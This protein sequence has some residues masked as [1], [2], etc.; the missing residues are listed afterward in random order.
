MLIGTAIGGRFLY[1]YFIGAGAGHMQS[2]ILASMMIV[3]GVQ[4]AIVGLQGDIIA[5]NRKLLEDIQYRVKCIEQKN[6][7]E[8]SEEPDR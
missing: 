5:A 7:Q 3:I 6:Y 4:S 1:F 2:L 8:N